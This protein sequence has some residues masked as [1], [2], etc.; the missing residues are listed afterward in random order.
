M[1]LDFLFLTLIFLFACHLNVQEDQNI[2]LDTIRNDIL[3]L[4][5]VIKLKVQQIW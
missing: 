1:I 2:Q 5:N 4:N 3:D